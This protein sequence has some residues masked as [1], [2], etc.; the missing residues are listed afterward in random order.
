MKHL[1]VLFVLLF[2]GASAPA[3]DKSPETSVQEK[4]VTGGS[5]RMHLSSGGY[6][7]RGTDS[8]E[9]A[10]TFS[11]KNYARLKDVKVKFKA[12]KN[13]A[14]LWLQNTPQ[15]NFQATIEV[16]RRSNLW[17]RLSAGQVEIGGVEGDKDVETPLVKSTFRFHIPKTMAIGTLRFWQGVLRPPPSMFPREDCGVLSRRQA[18]VNTACMRTL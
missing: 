2:A 14:D 9:I 15:S 3:E 12:N 11:C 17:V 7:I 16:P 5:I 1:V 4:F 8:D 10:I 6:T 18:P 13:A